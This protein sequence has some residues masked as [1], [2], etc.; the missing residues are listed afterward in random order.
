[1]NPDPI[2]DVVAFLAATRWTTGIFWLLALASVAIAVYAFST[3]PSQRRVSHICDWAFRF[4]IGCMWWQQTLW[5]LPPAYTDHP[6]QPFGETG[7][8][9]WMGVMG[10]VRRDSGSGRF[11]QQHRTAAFL[12]VR[13]DGLRS[14]GA[15]RGVAAPR[16]YMRLWG[17]VGALQIINLWLGL[18]SAPGEW[19]WTYF[20]FCC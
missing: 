2:S 11:C 9:Y 8:A 13:A 4:L 12:S 20:F 6:E 5:K 10:E 14:R 15:D 1:M 19:P 7:L 17:M 3:I 18:Y 16:A